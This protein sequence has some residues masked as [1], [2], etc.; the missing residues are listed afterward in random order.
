M[1]VRTVSCMTRLVIK[2]LNCTT[3]LSKL[4]YRVWHWLSL[5]CFAHFSHIF[6]TL[7]PNFFIVNFFKEFGNDCLGLVL[8]TF[9]ILFPHFF[10]T[11]F[12]QTFSRLFFHTFSQTFFIEKIKIHILSHFPL[13]FSHTFFHSF[14]YFSYTFSKL[15]SHFSHIFL[16]FFSFFLVCSLVYTIHWVHSVTVHWLYCTVLYCIVL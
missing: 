8:H 14:W 5:P 4:T 11:F 16:V 13:Y 2:L 10:Q 9:A 7:F 3:G 12:V 6:F 15:F 1:T